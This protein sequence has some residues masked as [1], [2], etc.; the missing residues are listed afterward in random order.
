M[1]PADLSML[2]SLDALQQEGGVTGAARRVGLSTP[3]MSRGTIDASGQT[4]T[5]IGGNPPPEP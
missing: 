3:A 1:Q 5:S 4:M 2:V